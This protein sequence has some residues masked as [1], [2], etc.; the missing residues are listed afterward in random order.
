MP[1]A[2]LPASPTH[3]STSDD[4]FSR[5]T[6]SPRD[7]KETSSREGLES[8]PQSRSNLAE[9]AHI[10]RKSAKALQRGTH[11]LAELV[12]QAYCA[13][14]RDFPDAVIHLI[15]P[16]DD[17]N[18]ICL[19]DGDL[20]SRALFAFLR[21]RWRVMSKLPYPTEL[22][23]WIE[24]ESDHV[25]VRI[26]DSGSGVEFDFARAL[27]SEANPG[28]QFANAVT[29]RKLALA[30]RAIEAHGGEV[31]V[32]SEPG[33][34]ST[35]WIDLPRQPLHATATDSHHQVKEVILAG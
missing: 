7:E 26:R 11:D 24:P 1:H 6:G 3:A 32:D 10:R 20:V 30:R 18:T 35:L 15:K 13:T 27:N 28:R 16:D 33:H 2:H 5:E 22:L 9:T 19:C 17:V 23:V 25:L 8:T 14:M 31:G 12:R 34:G 4:D 29:F 21:H